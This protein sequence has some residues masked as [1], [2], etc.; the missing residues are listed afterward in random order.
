MVALW[1]CCSTCMIAWKIIKIKEI[2][3]IVCVC[4]FVV[5]VEVFIILTTH[6]YTEWATWMNFHKRKCNSRRSI[7][8]TRN[9]CTR[10]KETKKICVYR[11]EL[12]FCTNENIF[13]IKNFS[14]YFEFSFFFLFWEMCC[15]LKEMD[16][17]M[18][19]MKYV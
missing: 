3:T 11:W 12:W 9:Y 4:T 1:P 7:P 17:W 18:H 14:F 2:T 19:S 15:I 13:I 5:V 6:S 16:G 10:A 8:I